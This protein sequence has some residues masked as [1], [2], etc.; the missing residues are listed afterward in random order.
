MD[1]KKKNIRVVV[2]QS[3]QQAIHY[4][5]NKRDNNDVIIPIGPEAMFEA[6]SYGWDI[7]NLGELWSTKDYEQAHS[8]SQFRIDALIEMLDIYSINWHSELD[9]EIGHYYG[10]QLWVI[11]GQIHYNYFIA[12]SIIKNF[13]PSKVVIYTSDVCENFMGLRPSPDC[14]FVNVFLNSGCIKRKFVEVFR[15]SEHAIQRTSRE[16][17]VSL[18][19]S[20]LIDQIRIIR[21]RW[22]F[23]KFGKSKYR[24]LMIG[25][26]YDWIK[27]SRDKDFKKLFKISNLSLL[28]VKKKVCPPEELIKIMN[29]SVEYEGVLIYDIK[30]LALA[31][32]SDLVFYIKN[33]K[34]II[35]RLQR[36]DAVITAVL[37]FP[38]EN[39]LAHMANRLNI[40]V[41]IWQ[42]GE[43]GQSNND[44][45]AWYTELCYATD[46]L[47]YGTEVVRR[48]QSWL[49]KSRLRN[50][51]AVGSI[52]K[53]V[54]WSAGETIVYATGKWM[55]TAASFTPRPD[56]DTRLYNAHKVILGYFDNA[57]DNLDVV[58]KA[59][60]TSGLNSIPYQYENIDV[61]FTTPFAKLLETAKIVVLDTPATTLV[62]ACSTK[63]PIFILG[64]RTNYLPDFLEKIKRRAVWC[65]NPNDLV[66]KI[67]AYL[68]KGIYEADINDDVYYREYCAVGDIG[69]VTYRTSK[70]LINAIDRSNS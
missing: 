1:V 48:Y 46:Y 60:N 3:K 24:L 52:G 29:T 43:K 65:E 67:D 49:G 61:D 5:E 11:I 56:P 37:S 45:S 51:K 13:Q 22:R 31:I 39:Y 2:L 12:Q 70:Y 18:F 42:H 55:K 7:C 47:A 69:D 14:I 19:P 54:V 38:L 62:E 28:S 20:S 50:V 6:D 16:K 40:P 30:D 9:L 59:N 17:I 8:D 57:M 66:I 35:S 27:V 36:Y 26:V 34:R 4:S 63:V 23:R 32:H 64:W 53:N 33:N 44:T 15:I 21:N 68:H 25:G 41:V 10:F 58:F